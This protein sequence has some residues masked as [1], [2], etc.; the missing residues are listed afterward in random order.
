MG[1]FTKEVDIFFDM[2]AER[3][4]TTVELLWEVL[5]RQMYVEAT[6]NSIYIVSIIIFGLLFVF[7]LRYMVKDYINSEWS[8]LEDYII[9]R[10]GF[11]IMFILTAS[12][13]FFIVGLIFLPGLIG[14]IVGRLV[15]PEYYA[16][17]LLMEFF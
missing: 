2:M 4:G 16:L 15:N 7:A 3:F 11:T 14:G 12:G 1:E 17:K 9:Y 6:I 10:L 5:I 8:N 13:V